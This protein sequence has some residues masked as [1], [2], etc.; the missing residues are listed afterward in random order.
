[1]NTLIN[2]HDKRAMNRDRSV[3]VRCS[4][5]TV[6]L[7]F[8]FHHMQGEDAD[9]FN[10]DRFIDENGQLAPPIDDTRDGVSFIYI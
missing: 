10:P 6:G 7:P 5:V 4:S 2:I 3:Y 1:L 8:S 9:D